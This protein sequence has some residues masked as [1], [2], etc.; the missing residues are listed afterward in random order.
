MRTVL[1]LSKLKLEVAWFIFEE[2]N[3]E[4]LLYSFENDLRTIKCKVYAKYNLIYKNILI[5]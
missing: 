3:M 1:N 5:Q 4:S 2:T